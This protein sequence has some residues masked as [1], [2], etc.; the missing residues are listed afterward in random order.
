M[1]KERN[2]FEIL[3]ILDRKNK[4][5]TS[6]EITDELNDLGIP[7]TSRMI[8]H[9]LQQLD[10]KGFTVNLGKV[11]REITEG[12]RDELKNSF[13]Y[14]RKDFIFDLIG[15]AVTDAHFDL[16]R[17]RGELITSLALI[18]ED[19][20][21]K[22]RG[23]LEEICAK[24]RLFS[25]LVKIAH[26]GE[27]LCRREVPEGVFGLA[28]LCSVVVDQILVNN[29]VFMHFG[30]G[31]IIETKNQKPV[32]CTKFASGSGISFDTWEV[33]IEHKM[34]NAYEGIVKGFGGVLAEY[35]EV[36]YTARARVINLLRKTVNILGG[37]VVVGGY[38]DNLLGV[39][40]RKGYTGLLTVAADSL[41]AALEEKGIKTNYETITPPVNFK[42]LEPIAPVKGEV[43]LL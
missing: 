41:I 13:V 30:D 42:E 34:V 21:D 22:V 7:L 25:P 11:G 27:K 38:A 10:K 37:T 3:S 28:V 20:E 39:P 43:L 29:G 36:P 26:S 16:N 6:A 31:T 32:R 14:A 17:Q 2:I 35:C 24:T 19:K 12:G 9:Y 4:P 1:T 23:I 5:M 8:R 18:E 33:F 40:T 15:Q